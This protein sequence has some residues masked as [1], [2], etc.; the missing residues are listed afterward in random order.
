[1]HRTR[2]ARAMAAFLLILTSGLSVIGSRWRLGPGVQLALIEGPMNEHAVQPNFPAY[3]RQRD[4]QRQSVS[5][6]D[7]FAAEEKDC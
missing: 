3:A 6:A 4:D 2:I 1:M 7:V 5:S